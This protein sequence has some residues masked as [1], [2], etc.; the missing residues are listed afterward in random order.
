MELGGQ[1][2]GIEPEEVVIV[3]AGDKTF[4]LTTLQDAGAVV[5]YDITDPEN[6]KYDSGA[7]TEMNDYTSDT[8]GISVEN[9]KDLPI[10]MDT[11]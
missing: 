11:F 10:K 3:E 1:R 2:K 5:V 6:P 4:V 9:P 8:A 7:I